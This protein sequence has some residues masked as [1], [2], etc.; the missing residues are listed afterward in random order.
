MK[1]IKLVLQNRRSFL[2]KTLSSCVACSL[3]TSDIFGVNNKLLQEE[4]HKFDSESKMTEQDVYN[5]AFK[6]WYIPAMKNLMKQVGKEHFIKILKRASDMQYERNNKNEV[7]YSSNTLQRWAS[8]IIKGCEEWNTKLTYEVLTN[9][10]KLFEIKFTEC[11]WAK[12]FREAKASE[13]GFA[14]VCYKDYGVTKAYNPKMQLTREMTLMQGDEC[15]HFK[16]TME[17]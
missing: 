10:E 9:N 13:I 4:K 2:L 14:G 7:D 16:W 17:A 8:D 11:L 15:C 6:Q 12:T 5:F 3:A 1:S